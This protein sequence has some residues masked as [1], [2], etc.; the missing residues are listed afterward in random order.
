MFKRKITEKYIRKHFNKK[1]SS[2]FEAYF[3]SKIP[4]DVW[5][6]SL[7]IEIRDN[8]VFSL[9]MGYSVSSYWICDIKY[10]YQLKQMLKIYGIKIKL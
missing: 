10:V 2:I 9:V 1:F 5:S 6:N 3:I 8:G 7:A 4:T